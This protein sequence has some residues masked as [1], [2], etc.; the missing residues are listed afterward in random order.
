MEAITMRI[1]NLS[2]S[3]LIDD[4]MMILNCNDEDRQVVIPGSQPLDWKE[5]LDDT[6][7][8]IHEGD[9]WLTTE[10]DQIDPRIKI[11]EFMQVVDVIIEEYLDRVEYVLRVLKGGN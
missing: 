6:D 4:Q 9:I 3:E 5:F 8:A 7:A 2:V 10:I 11:K 1:S